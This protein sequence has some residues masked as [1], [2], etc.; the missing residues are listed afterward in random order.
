LS[1]ALFTET[2]R[3]NWCS[4]ERPRHRVHQLRGHSGIICEYCLEWHLHAL[5]FLGGALPNG[6]QGCD[7]TRAELAERHPLEM[8]VRMYV[9]PKDGILQMLCGDCA[10]PYIGKRSDLYRGTQFG[11]NQL[12]L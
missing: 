12:H 2:H 9:V 4:R 7:A 5:D 11:H 10:G 6:C 3:C 8:A 1:L